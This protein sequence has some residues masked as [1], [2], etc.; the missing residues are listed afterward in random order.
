[1]GSV[2]LDFSLFLDTT[3]I[4]G[5]HHFRFMQ[6]NGNNS[7]TYEWDITDGSNHWIPTGVRG[8]IQQED[9]NRFSLQINVDAKHNF[10]YHSITMNG[11]KAILDRAYPPII[12]KAHAGWWGAQP[13]FQIDSL[14][15][16]LDCW[17]RNLTVEIT[18]G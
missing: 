11:E 18:K 6:L 1:V 10:R 7:S 16:P 17:A 2:E 5:A 3:F 4:P 12:L 14:G 9:W 15:K 13:N 8:E